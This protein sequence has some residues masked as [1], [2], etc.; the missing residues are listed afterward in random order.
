M[1]VNAYHQKAIMTKWEY[2]KIKKINAK[3]IKHLKSFKNDLEN[4]KVIVGA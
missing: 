2:N 4:V 1:Q 3:Y